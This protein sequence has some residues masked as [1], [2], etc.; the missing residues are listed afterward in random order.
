MPDASFLALLVLALA[1]CGPRVHP[2]T[3][4]DDGVT[5]SNALLE[6]LP[7]DT[8][9]CSIAVSQ[10]GVVLWAGARGLADVTSR[11]P[12]DT[13]SIFDIASTSKQ[14]TA[15]AVLLLA[16]DGALT[17]NDSLA[18]RVSGL[19]A[20]ANDV[21][22]EQLMHHTSGIP[23]YGDLLAKRGVELTAP[24]TQAD[25]LTALASATL[26]FMP[27]SKFT[28]SNSNYLLLAEV[29]NAVTGKSLPAL[30][31]ERVFKPLQL[32][33]RMD[34]A[35]EAPAVAVPYVMR[36]L[37]LTASRSR[38]LQLGDGSIFTTPSQL[39]RWGDNYR[40]GAVGGLELITA[41]L[42]AAVPTDTPGDRYGPGIDLATN[43]SLSHSGAWS[44][45][46]TVFV[47]SADRSRVLAMSCNSFEMNAPTTVGQGLMT[48]WL[49]GH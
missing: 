3:S 10:E 36:G 42:Q 31:D 23:D 40:T 20:W 7:A 25:A 37:A 1:G 2:M 47:V 6:T 33:M 45:F 4:V 43:G 11:Q 35:F 26:G 27:G 22:L 29:V 5:Q 9:G 18:S 19:P 12:L 38:W 8:P 17:L 49:E 32:D 24:S 48:I 15:L 13:N 44:G 28:Y 21:T 14:F 34:P 39:A 16:R 30:L 41:A 46:A